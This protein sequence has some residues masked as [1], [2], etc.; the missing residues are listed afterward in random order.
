MNRE[1]PLPEE[2]TNVEAG[3]TFIREIVAMGIGL[4]LVYWGKV[5]GPYLMTFIAYV[6][7][8]HYPKPRDMRKGAI[9]GALGNM[10][11]SLVRSE[12]VV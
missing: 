6:I 10:G 4:L 8:A 3:T 1:T 5:E 11:Q 2:P 7:A 12:S 9:R